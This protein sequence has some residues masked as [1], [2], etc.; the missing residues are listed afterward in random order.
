MTAKQAIYR[1]ELLHA[2]RNALH[3]LNMRLESYTREQY[4]R[5]VQNAFTR[6]YMIMAT[7]PCTQSE[8]AVSLARKVGA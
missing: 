3:A 8:S 4:Y 7:D 5:D 1:T 6:Y 2:V